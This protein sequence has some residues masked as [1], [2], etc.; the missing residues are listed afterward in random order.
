MKGEKICLFVWL[1]VITAAILV[2]LKNPQNDGQFED[3]KLLVNLFGIWSLLSS[4]FHVK[5]KH[6]RNI[7][8]KEKND[9][10][11]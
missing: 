2:R 9:E 11:N 8:E 3:V 5:K 7:E 1:V 4:F 10:R 6:N